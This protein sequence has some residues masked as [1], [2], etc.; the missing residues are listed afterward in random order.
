MEIVQ[1]RLVIVDADPSPDPADEH[2]HAQIDARRGRSHPARSAIR[3]LTG[4]AGPSVIVDAAPEPRIRPGT[5]PATPPPPEGPRILAWLGPV[6]PLTVAALL[7]LWNLGQ[8]GYG[9]LYYSVAVQSM[10]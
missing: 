5:R 9:Y 1:A 4:R 6:V 3:Q 2:E 7:N 10:M 8:I